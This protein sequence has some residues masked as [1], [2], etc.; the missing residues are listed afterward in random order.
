MQVIEYIRA[1]LMARL[2][3][4]HVNALMLISGAFGIIR[5]DVAVDVGGYSHGTVGE[6]LEIIVKIHRL[7]REAKRDYEIVYIPDP[8]CWT[9][10]P[11]SVRLLARQRMRW[12][13]GALETFFKHAVMLVN[14]RYGMAGI[15]GFGQ[16]L[17]SDVVAPP[18]E[19]LGYVLMPL[20]WWMGLMSWDMFAAYLALTFSLGVF[21]SVG[22]LILEELELKRFPR[23]HHLAVLMVVAV[24]ENFGYRQVNNLW[25][26]AGWWQFLRGTGGWGEMH[27]KGFNIVKRR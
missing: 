15:V 6:D 5:R 24:L 3:W 13:R 23:A 17:I 27:R 10:A 21:I 19:A 18:A 4:S 1:F 20:F 22:S 9:E 7:M 2:A 12:Q 8:V 16:T 25:R 26:M 11:E 14:P